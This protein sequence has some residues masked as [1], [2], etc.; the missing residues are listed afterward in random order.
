MRSHALK[1]YYS[2]DVFGK[3]GVKSVEETKS[4]SF[5]NAFIR[6]LCAQFG[7]GTQ[8]IDEIGGSPINYGLGDTGFEINISGG[9][10]SHP[11]SISSLNS[12]MGI[13]VGTSDQAVVITDYALISKVDHGNETGQLEYFGSFV[14]DLV[15]AG[16]DASVYFERIFRNSSGG[17]IDINEIGVYG[18]TDNGTIC[19]IRDVLV[20]P[21]AVADDEYLKVKYTIKVSA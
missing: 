21:V 2:L 6:A 14:S 5:V 20:S 17:S 9:G 18:Y 19:T 4:K 12:E 11:Y 7:G 3:G 1:A 10:G 15:V 13:V 8:S 16:S